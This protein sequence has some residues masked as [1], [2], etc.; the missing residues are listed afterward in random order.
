VQVR[1]LPG[2][3]KPQVTGVI[4][5]VLVL[6]SANLVIPSVS[7]GAMIATLERIAWA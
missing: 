3:P 5:P 2:A 1:V 7:I 6:P 4:L